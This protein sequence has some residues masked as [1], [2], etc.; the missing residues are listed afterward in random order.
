MEIISYRLV[1]QRHAR[2]AFDGEGARLYGGRWNS[3]GIPIVYTSDSLALCCLEI[4]VHLPSYHLLKDYVYM[5]VGFDSDLVTEAQLVDGW[6]AS[7][8]SKVSQSIGDQWVSDNVSPILL[9]PSVI[10]PEGVSYLLNIAHPDF[11]RIKIG[12]QV[13]MDFD[14]RLRKN[15]KGP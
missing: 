12:D 4:F 14:P 3:Q 10:I 7:P 6:D 5:Q 9:V 2:S 15:L 11:D 1:K 8:V 13:E